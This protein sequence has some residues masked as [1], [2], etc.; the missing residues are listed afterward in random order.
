LRTTLT[1]LACLAAF[2]LAACGDDSDDAT[3]GGEEAEAT[4]S[5]DQAIVEI[6]AVRGGLDEALLAYEE[7][8][9]AAAE[10]AATDAYLEHFELVEG[11]L[12]E[13]DEELNEEL[14]ILIRETLGEAIAS[15]APVAE[16]EKL[17]EEAN[18]GLDD[19][20]AQLEKA[21]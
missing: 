8:D 7:G 2:S 14:E 16:V 1:I 11:P 5:A 13:T 17:V 10:E 21:G 12:E 20:E 19:A 18:A 4:V 6:K 9:A 3:D 15:D